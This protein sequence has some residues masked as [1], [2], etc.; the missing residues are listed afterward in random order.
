MFELL[1]REFL[2]TPHMP[3]RSSLARANLVKAEIQKFG[4]KCDSSFSLPLPRAELLEGIRDSRSLSYMVSEILSGR[5]FN[6]SQYDADTQLSF[7][8]SFAGFLS[9]LDSV[10]WVHY[11]LYGFTS[12]DFATRTRWFAS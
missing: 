4:Y 3:E 10:P 9:H 6:F 1:L 11:Y 7:K 8:T 12:F 5:H 2:C